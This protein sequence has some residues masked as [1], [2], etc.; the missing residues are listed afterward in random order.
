[1]NIKT[2]VHGLVSLC[3]ALLVGFVAIPLTTEALFRSQHDDGTKFEA[4]VPDV[5]EI[6]RQYHQEVQNKRHDYYEAMEMYR[7]RLKDGEKDLPKPD[8]NNQTTVDFYF[9][10]ATLEE[11]VH[12][13]SPKAAVKDATTAVLAN[14]TISKE[15]RALLRRYER[16]GYCPESLKNYVAGFYDLCT[17]LAGRKLRSA[18]RTGILNDLVRIKSARNVLPKTLDSRLEMLRQAREGSKRESIGPSRTS[19][20]A[21]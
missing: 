2:N 14:E 20:P 8:V 17:S 18:P 12:A 10:R 3:L 16:A 19:A 1:M 21:K 4:G 9:G 5:M 6:A 13:A 11:A 15:D 7:E